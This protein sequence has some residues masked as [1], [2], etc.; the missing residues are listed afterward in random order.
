LRPLDGAT[1]L[2][3]RLIAGK[4]NSKQ[5]RL[6]RQILGKQSVARALRER[7]PLVEDVDDR[8]KFAVLLI[9]PSLAVTDWFPEC[10]LLN[11]AGAWA[12]GS[13]VLHAISE[14]RS[15]LAG[16]ARAV[17]GPPLNK[18]ATALWRP[19]TLSHLLVDGL[20][21]IE[22]ELVVVPPPKAFSCP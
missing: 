3:T 14:V 9:T 2:N 10:P 12:Y 7:A 1:L 13:A 20:I 6:H 8:R 21:R 15:R 5:L 17:R 16:I 19:T 4:T 11:K 18:P 22:R